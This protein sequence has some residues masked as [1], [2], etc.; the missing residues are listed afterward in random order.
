MAM[1]GL[2]PSMA[3]FRS[4]QMCI[5]LNLKSCALFLRGMRA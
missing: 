1:V 4:T 5:Y 3:M 2:L